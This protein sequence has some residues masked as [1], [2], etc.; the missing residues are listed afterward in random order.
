[1]NT[2]TNFRKVTEELQSSLDSSFFPHSN[3]KKNPDIPSFKSPVSWRSLA[4]LSV[5]LHALNPPFHTE[6]SPGLY[7]FKAIFPPHLQLSPSRK[8]TN[9]NPHGSYLPPFLLFWCTVFP[10]FNFYIY[11]I[12]L[13]TFFLRTTLAGGG[14]DIFSNKQVHLWTFSLI[15]S[16]D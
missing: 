6:L 3:V 15:F 14:G 5:F 7:W 9:N 11:L 16:T 1:L 10:F 4:T 2:A 8:N 13:F 12:S